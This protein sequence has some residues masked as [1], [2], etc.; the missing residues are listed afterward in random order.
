VQE[1]TVRT[2]RSPEGEAEAEREGLVK[3]RAWASGGRT[4]EDKSP[5]H[6]DIATAIATLSTHT[7]HTETNKIIHSHTLSIPSSPAPIS[8]SIY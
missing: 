7:Q 1:V 6:R 2:M 8:R 4:E 5:K 3:L